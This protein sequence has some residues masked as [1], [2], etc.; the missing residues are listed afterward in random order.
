MAEKTAVFS[1]KVDT[2]KSVQDIQAFDKAVEDLNKDLKDT[3]KT[4]TDASTKGMETFD[5]KLAELNQTLENGGLSMREM[6]NHERISELGSQSWS[7][8]S[9]WKASHFKC[10]KS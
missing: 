9:S 3:S 5:Q 4:A 6:T 1:L 2:G 8:E 10:C 7:R